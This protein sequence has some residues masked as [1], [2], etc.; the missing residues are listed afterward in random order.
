MHASRFGEQWQAV[1]GLS[2]PKL[3]AS[4]VFPGTVS[5]V[6][7]VCVSC[8]HLL[9]VYLDNLYL[10]VYAN[11][12]TCTGPRRVFA[13]RPSRVPGMC[14][15]LRV[16]VRVRAGMC[17]SEREIERERKRES[18]CA[19]STCVCM[20]VHAHAMHTLCRT[21]RVHIQT[22]RIHAHRGTMCW[23]CKCFR[24]WPA[25]LLSA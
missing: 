24:C 16:H 7:C 9:L 2:M 11:M 8:V 10:Y 3:E 23:N 1:R 20:C 13:G 17:G 4:R 25:P 5:I 19:C 6:V 12:R 15:Q 18:L 22:H 14:L 21:T